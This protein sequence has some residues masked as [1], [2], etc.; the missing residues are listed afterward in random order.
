V[1]LDNRGNSKQR[2]L[3]NEKHQ[4][5]K[6]VLFYS[7]TLISLFILNKQSY[8]CHPVTHKG[9]TFKLTGPELPGLINLNPGVGIQTAKIQDG[10]MVVREFLG[11]SPNKAYSV[12]IYNNG[13]L[14]PGPF[15]IT[16][17][18]LAQ[19][20]T[21]S[22]T[23]AASFAEI[24]RILAAQKQCNKPDFNPVT[25]TGQSAPR[26]TASEAVNTWR[27]ERRAP[28]PETQDPIQRQRRQRRIEEIEQRAASGNTPRATGRVVATVTGSGLVNMREDDPNAD[29]STPECDPLRT[30]ASEDTESDGVSVDDLQACIGAIQD[31]MLRGHPSPPSTSARVEIFRRLQA[32]PNEEQEFAAA[33][34]TARG[35]AGAEEEPI[36]QLMIMK[37]L[38]NRRNNLNE[39]EDKIDECNLSGSSTEEVRSCIAD[40]QE[41][42]RYNLLDIALDDQ[43]FSMYNAGSGGNWTTT[44]GR[45]GTDFSKEIANFLKYDQM[46]EVSISGGDGRANSIDRIYHYHTKTVSPDWENDSQKLTVSAQTKDGDSLGST[47]AHVFYFQLESN[48]SPTGDGWAR[49]RTYGTLNRR[50]E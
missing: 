48:F 33:I 44:I 49:S 25:L 18:Q 5:C 3:R 11:A 39:V 20:R 50:M 29:N 10:K 37:V 46:G 21:Q 36:E 26:P 27:E 38:S 45:K 31:K 24:N 28:D 42:T 16:D 43:Q 8:A 9:C 2:N 4:T 1:T 32:L 6:K 22:A 12:D 47:G 34:F 14:I 7:L 19:M 35:E 15:R 17:K 13:K 41:G 40:A 30:T 23:K